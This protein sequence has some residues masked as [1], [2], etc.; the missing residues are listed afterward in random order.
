MSL[1]VPGS[2]IAFVRSSDR[3]KAT[4]DVIGVVSDKDKRPLA[5]IRDTAKLAV[6]TS[7]E[8]R[9]KNVQYNTALVLPSGKYHLKFVVRENQTGRMGSF[10][11]DMEIPELKS[12]PLKM[13]SI[14]LASQLQPAKKTATPNP[15]IHDGS[16]IIPNV[17]HVFSASQHL[18]LYYEVYDPGRSNAPDSSDTGPAKAGIHLLS[19]VAFFRGKA[20]VFESSP[21]DLT[22]LNAR[23]RKAGVFQLDLPLESLKPGF[24]TCQVNVIDDAGGHFLFPR[25]ALLIRPQSSGSPQ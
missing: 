8:V 3:D 25:L 4:L 22:E 5:T 17:T 20:K 11:T 23:D 2:Q 14:V 16:E 19:N 9:K 21:V 18:L 15:L 24:Y 12:Q 1:V 10:E 13:S 6:E 7:T